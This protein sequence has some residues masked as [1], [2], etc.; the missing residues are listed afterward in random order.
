MILHVSLIYHLCSYS[1]H[2][3]VAC[4][5]SSFAPT[6]RMTTYRLVCSRPL[7]GTPTERTPCPT[8]SSSCRPDDSYVTHSKSSSSAYELLNQSLTYLHM[9]SLDQ[10]LTHLHMTSLNQSLTHLHIRHYSFNFV[11]ISACNFINCAG[12]IVNS[13]IIFYIFW[14]ILE[15]DN[16]HI[17]Q[18]IFVN[19]S[20]PNS[21]DCFLLDKYGWGCPP[22]PTF[23]N[24]DTCL[25]QQLH[26]VSI[27][28]WKIIL[29]FVNF[30][31]QP[32]RR[33]RTPPFCAYFNSFNKNTLTCVFTFQNNMQTIRINCVCLL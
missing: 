1:R 32:W 22:L 23:K 21:D 20:R 7:I 16:I 5:R 12:N 33:Y 30:A 17:F 15:S 3:I 19:K 11:L 18:Y 25:M 14:I 24:D 8:R 4:F 10:I 26:A 28:V 27:K 31:S 9:T 6:P 29:L 13:S 2:N